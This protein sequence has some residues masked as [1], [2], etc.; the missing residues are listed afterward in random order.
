MECNLIRLCHITYCQLLSVNSQAIP[1]QLTIRRTHPEFQARNA[2]FPVAWPDIGS[3]G[4]SSEVQQKIGKKNSQKSYCPGDR[5][6][7]K[8]I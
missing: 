2:D 3:L 6:K 1:L 4:K 8:T 7:K 5:E